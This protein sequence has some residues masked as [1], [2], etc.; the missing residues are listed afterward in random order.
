MNGAWGN[1]TGRRFG[2]E[3]ASNLAARYLEAD[4]TEAKVM[5]SDTSAESLGVLYPDL[6]TLHL[7][8]SGDNCSDADFVRLCELNPEMRFERNADGSVVVMTPSGA[9][10]SGSN[11]EIARELGVWSKKNKT[12]KGFDSSGLF[13]LP[14]GAIR[15]PDASWI[16]LERWNALSREDKRGAAPIVPDFVVELKSPSDRMSHLRKKMQEYLE[17]GVRLGWLI[18]PDAKVVEIYR[19]GAEVEVLK[20]PTFVSGD[21]ELAGFQMAMAEIWSEET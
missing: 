11:F 4:L 18:D 21:P 13:K 19:P 9:E 15:C 1:A 10:S 20:N 3:F 14:N 5:A 12:G 17:A 2:A 7:P 8:T 6:V 16:L